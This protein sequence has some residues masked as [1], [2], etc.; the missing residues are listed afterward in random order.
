MQFSLQLDHTMQQVLASQGIVEARHDGSV[1]SYGQAIMLQAHRQATFCLHRGVPL[2]HGGDGLLQP[3]LVVRLEVY[4]GPVDC[5]AGHAGPG[6]ALFFQHVQPG[7][8]REP[9]VIGSRVIRQVLLPVSPFQAKGK[10][11]PVTLSEQCLSA[12]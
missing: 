2:P 4:Q 9:S 12:S 6:L 10:Q 5:N 11:A 7:R 8:T 1:W 3:L